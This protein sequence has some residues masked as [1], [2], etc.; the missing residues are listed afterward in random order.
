VSSLHLKVSAAPADGNTDDPAV[1]RK[2]VLK[3]GF[4]LAKD[5]SS[6]HRIG[7]RDKVFVSA[8][9]SD[10]KKELDILFKKIIPKLRQLSYAKDTIFSV[11]CMDYGF[12]DGSRPLWEEHLSAVTDSCKESTNLA[13]LSFISDE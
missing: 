6:W 2:T 11:V 9:T 12:G 3:G 10:C 4:A 13:F 1:L 7:I 8:T 5:K